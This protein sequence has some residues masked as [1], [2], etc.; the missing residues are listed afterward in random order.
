[1]TCGEETVSH[2]LLGGVNERSLVAPEL[3]V[4]DPYRA[5]YAPSLTDDHPITANASKHD[6]ASAH[7]RGWTSH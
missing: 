7:V 6:R 3:D 5:G 2:G 4:L 1:M